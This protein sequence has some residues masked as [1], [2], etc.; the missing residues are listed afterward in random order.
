MALN[1]NQV[2]I[3][4]VQSG[5]LSPEEARRIAVDSGFTQ[6]PGEGRAQTFFDTDKAANEKALQQ[7]AQAGAIPTTSLNQHMGNT[8]NNPQLPTGA[9][10]IPQT[11]AVQPG[12]MATAP[13]VTAGQVSTPD[14][15]NGQNLTAAQVTLDDI[16]VGYEDA[17]SKISSATGTYNPYLVSGNTPQMEAAQG[18]V[19]ELAT[20]QGQLAKLYGES[21]DGQIPIWA[22]GAMR[23]AQE[24]M[25]ARGLGASSIAAGAITAAIQ[26]SAIN[27]AAQ[28]AATYFQMDI[29]NL[30]NEQQARLENVRLQQQSLLSDQAAINAAEQF[31][32]ASTQQLEMFQANLVSNIQSQNANRVAAIR[33]FNAASSNEMQ[34]A[35]AQLNQQADMFNV[36]QRTAV[37]QFNANLKF[38]AE[39]FNAQM[40]SVVDQSNVNWRRQINTAN[41]ASINAAN[42]LNVQNAFNL[43]NYALNALWQKSRDEADWLWQSARDEQQ[44]MY[45]L[46]LVGANRDASAYLT[47]VKA[48]IEEDME[49]YKALGVLGN[50][51]IQKL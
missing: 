25:G 9:T 15:V 50:E 13:K 29:T 28:D 14:T 19:S 51:I 12:E 27:I 18:Q 21:S 33:Q 37:E 36:Q 22:Q 5:K 30:G 45:N 41:T 1:A 11:M 44:Y 32:A 43:S 10:M 24:V 38:Q 49:F 3:Q 26:E 47:N 7:L 40:A 34:L 31:N 46:G 16:L 42:Q 17:L 39:T 35:G 23:K 48:N 4:A 6:A 8:V 2:I 20:V